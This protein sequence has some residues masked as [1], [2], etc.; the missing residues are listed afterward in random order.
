MTLNR[1]AAALISFGIIIVGALV[2]IPDGEFGVTAGIQLG[3][4]AISTAATYFIPLAPIRWQGI[5]KT[6]TAVA[7]A[8][9]QALIPLITGGIYNR[10]TIGLVVLAIVQALGTEFGVGIRKTAALID[11]RESGVITNQIGRAHV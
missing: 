9:L 4:L 10:I 11:A 7:L 6:G 3:I 5:G 1:Y 2:A 8:A